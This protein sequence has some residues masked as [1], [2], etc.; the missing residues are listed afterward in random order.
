M[1]LYQVGYFS[2]QIGWG[3]FGVI[4]WTL[5]F[6]ML[7]FQLLDLLL[8]PCTVSKS[9]NLIYKVH[10][11][12]TWLLVLPKEF[13]DQWSKMLYTFYIWAS[14][15]KN[16]NNKTTVNCYQDLLV[17]FGPI[18]G[19]RC[20]TNCATANCTRTYKTTWLAMS[21]VSIIRHGSWYR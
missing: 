12:D 17:T 11:H 13:L 1:K 20:W 8:S 10:T 15:N 6:M 2:Y 16:N 19:I 3:Q 9:M 18:T 5:Q 4:R 14:L 21:V 7:I